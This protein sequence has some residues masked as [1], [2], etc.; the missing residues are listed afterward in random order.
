MTADL[1]G[2]PD[3]QRAK[4]ET[5]LK[6]ERRKRKNDDFLVAGLETGTII[7]IKMSNLEQ[8]YARFSVHRHAIAHIAEL[9]S[10]NLMLTFCNEYRLA[11]WGFQN[12]KFKLFRQYNLFR[13]LTQ[14]CVFN[15]RLLLN[16]KQGE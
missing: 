2:S 9:K 12:Y 3:N 1:E 11:I 8:I 6:A 7:F 10:Q 14:M 16:F 4:I 15:D 13:P 5:E